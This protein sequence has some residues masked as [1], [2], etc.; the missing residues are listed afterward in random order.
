MNPI[1]RNVLAVVAAWLGGGF[2][3]MGLVETG[4]R[5]M[6]IPFVTSGDMESLKAVIPSLEPKYFIFPFLAHAVGTLVGAFLVVK[7]AASR[8]QQLAYVIGILF[9]AGGIAVNYML[10]GPTWFV[11]LDL[12]VAYIPMAWLGHRLANR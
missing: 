2:V 1:L 5:L 10:G 6:P 3:N 4:N 8:K 7:L 9:L 12:I 11:M